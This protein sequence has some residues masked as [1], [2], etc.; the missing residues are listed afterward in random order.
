MRKATA[1]RDGA[2]KIAPPCETLSANKY[3]ATVPGEQLQR[4]ISHVSRKTTQIRFGK[5]GAHPQ[6]ALGIAIAHETLFHHFSLSFLKAIAILPV[7]S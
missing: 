2:N 6:L 5:A 7:L 1:F 3:L 4:S